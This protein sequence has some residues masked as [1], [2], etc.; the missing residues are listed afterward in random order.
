MDNKTGE[1]LEE[2]E[3][4]IFE[5]CTQDICSKGPLVTDIEVGEVM[6]QSCGIV[7]ADK[8]IET[9]NLENRAF[10]K[11]DF[12]SNTRVGPKLKLSFADMGLSTVIN[13]SNS[14]SSGKQLSGKIRADFSRLRKWDRHAKSK[15]NHKFNE[16]FVLLDA[17][18]SKLGLSESIVEKSAHIYRKAVSQRL[19][20]GRS[21][22]VLI[23]TAIY[24]ACRSTNTPRTLKD[25]ADAANVEKKN[26]QKIYR[27]LIIN[28]EL[29]PDAYEPTDFITRLSSSV[30]VHEKTRRNAIR[31]LLKAKKLGLTAGKNPIGMASAALYL[32]C[33]INN[34][35]VTQAQIAEA[36]GVT[37]VTVRT[38]YKNLVKIMGNEIPYG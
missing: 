34:E 11:E 10:T 25:V 12:I 14:D 6:C 22:T 24:A 29:T 27:L 8:T 4:N 5:K 28:L 23:S 20:K 16:P 21:K 31:V 26:L 1:L 17:I 36:A 35:K 18:R 2:E 32:S 3:E 38:Q 33:A 9:S 7:L 13:P 37:N 19:T 30:N 15:A